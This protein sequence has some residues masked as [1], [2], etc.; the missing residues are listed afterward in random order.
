VIRTSGSS[1]LTLIL[2]GWFSH[3]MRGKCELYLG[4]AVLVDD[5]Y[6]EVT[7]DLS[8]RESLQ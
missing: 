1:R 2:N 8:D 6:G 7:A 5:S 3:C 4:C